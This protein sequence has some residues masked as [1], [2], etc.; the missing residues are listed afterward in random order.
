MLG[1]KS[2]L[3]YNLVLDWKALHRKASRLPPLNQN[4]R[5]VFLKTEG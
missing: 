3:T 4:D 5:Q 2:D 1:S